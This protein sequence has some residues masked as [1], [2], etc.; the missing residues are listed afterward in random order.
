VL[1]NVNDHFIV[2]TLFLQEH[3]G[4]HSPFAGLGERS[5]Q[6]FHNLSTGDISYRHPQRF[7]VKIQV[8]LPNDDWPSTRLVVGSRFFSVGLL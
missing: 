5:V 7:T 6:R 8:L 1:R 3:M 2:L 4:S